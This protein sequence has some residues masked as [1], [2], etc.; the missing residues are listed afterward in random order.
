MDMVDLRI[1]WNRPARLPDG[2][3]EH[4]LLV[5][6]T[7]QAALSRLPGNFCLLLDCSGSMEGQK[8]EDARAACRLAL[9]CLQADDVWSMV[10]FN[11]AARPVLVGQSCRGLT[12]DAVNRHLAGLAAEGTTRLDPLSEARKAPQPNGPGTSAILVITD[13]HPTNA[14][15]TVIEDFLFLGT[16]GGLTQRITSSRSGSGVRAI[17]QRVPD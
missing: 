12:D 9:S 16:A 13:G 1:A 14:R 2:S 17:Q 10:S 7:P 15:G 6:V 4:V 5:G 8:L 11:S 3:S